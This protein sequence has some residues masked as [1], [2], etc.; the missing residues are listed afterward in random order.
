M[1]GEMHAFLAQP[2]VGFFSMIIIGALAGWIAER[3]TESDH[4]L[5]TNILM[6]IGGAFI[7]GKIAEL[8][9]IPVFGFFRTLIAAVI[10]AVI[11]IFIWRKIRSSQ[12]G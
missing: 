11:I 6:G 12:A 3:I 5:I 7:G 9:D 1:G 8:L 4:G 10:G 2:G